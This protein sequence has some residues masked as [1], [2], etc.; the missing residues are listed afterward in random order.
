[1]NFELYSESQKQLLIF[2]MLNCVL[3]VLLNFYAV[4]LFDLAE[5]PKNL[6]RFFWFLDYLKKNFNLLYHDRKP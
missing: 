3:I 1:M 2:C 4:T 5:A 6:N